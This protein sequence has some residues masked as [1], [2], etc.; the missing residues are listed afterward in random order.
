MVDNGI[1][2]HAA[3]TG[4]PDGTTARTFRAGER[5]EDLSAEYAELLVRKGHAQRDAV[6]EK[7][8]RKKET[9]R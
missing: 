2:V 7:Q 3:F 5:P 6:R 4:Y 9:T 8:P 1:T